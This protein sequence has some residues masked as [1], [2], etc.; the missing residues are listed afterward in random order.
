MPYWRFEKK[1]FLVVFFT[2]RRL[3]FWGVDLDSLR[4]L[5]WFEPHCL[6]GLTLEWLEI[7]VLFE[8][9]PVRLILRENSRHAQVLVKFDLECG[10]V[11]V[12]LFCAQLASN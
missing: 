11:L 3:L 10:P 2:F 7:L 6:E 9:D 8:Q 4:I 5:F 12:D 1:L